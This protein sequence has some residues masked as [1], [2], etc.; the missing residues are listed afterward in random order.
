[1]GWS[2]GNASIGLLSL[3]AHKYLETVK[4]TVTDGC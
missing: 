4:T 1:V 3:K 2:I